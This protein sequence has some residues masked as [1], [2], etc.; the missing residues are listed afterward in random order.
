MERQGRWLAPVQCFI[1]PLIPLMYLYARNAEY[2]NPMQTAA[3]GL[4]L[5]ASSLAGYFIFRAL[6]R[7]SL[8]ALAGCLTGCVLFFATRSVSG[9][10][11][12]NLD[13]I[14]FDRFLLFYGAA[15]LLVMLAVMFL[16]RGR[17]GDK[18]FPASMIFLGIL[19]VYNAVPAIGD[20]A[21]SVRDARAAEAVE[22]KTA[23]SVSDTAPSPNVYWFHCDGMLGFDAFERY[24]GDDQAA[25]KKA[26]ADRGF[27]INPT[28]T[29][30]ARH[31]TKYAV[32][33]LMCPDF[34]D[35]VLRPVLKDHITAMAEAPKLSV[36]TLGRACE[37]SEL[38]TAF[39][40]KGYVS[41][42]FNSFSA[43][44]PPV[45][46]RAYETGDKGAVTLERDDRFV[47]Q[48]RNVLEAQELASLLTG[49]PDNTFLRAVATLS[50]RGILGFTF[51]SQ[52]IQHPLTKE[53]LTSITQ[54]VT[55]QKKTTMMLGA[56][57]DS[58]FQDKPT[59]D[60]FYYVRAH[61]PFTLKEDGS[62]NNKDTMAVE[63]YAPQHKYVARTLLVMIDEILAR[64]PDAVI[65]LQ[66]DH[67][68]HGN[69]EAEITEAF[70]KDAVIP[71]WNQVMSALRVPDKYKNGEEA[72][73]LS[74]PLNMS[75]YLVNA[76]VGRNY[77]YLP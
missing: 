37:N 54:G 47:A 46:D 58:T 61:Y 76:F 71:I 29:L 53:Q 45:S 3:V 50:E 5:A 65:V 27:Q 9:L 7:S 40:E 23:F 33:S 14:G 6:F 59:F 42:T 30:E 8:A 41:Q 68:L 19:F 35:S 28:A 4:L 20:G 52:P 34:Y 73:A 18:L 10:R 70:G 15:G 2:L 60:I 39:E 13:R 72:R 75:R 74:N 69:S 26:L 55:L 66:G 57:H 25:F 31:A 21:A 24:F 38:R 44:Y 77:D 36:R 62:P 12:V 32:P 56:I 43:Y 16:L 64:D 63:S 51:R 17:S 11:F 67:G 48:Y 22:F 1:L 49:I